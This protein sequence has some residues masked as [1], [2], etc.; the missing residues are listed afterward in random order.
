MATGAYSTL[1]AIPGRKIG[2]VQLV[3]LPEC[4]PPEPLGPPMGVPPQP[5]PAPTKHPVSMIVAHETA[6]STLSVPPSGK[7]IAT[8]S[9]RGT[10]VRVWDTVTGNRLR[11]LRRGSDQAEIYGV[12]F[13]PDEQE[14]CV[15]SDKGTVHVFSL[16]SGSRASYAFCFQP[17]LTSRI[18]VPRRNRHSKLSPLTPFLPQQFKIFGS[19]WSYATYSIPS[20]QSHIAL[21]STSIRSQS[22][23]IAEEDRC[24]VGWIRAAVDE[25]DPA[26]SEY[27]LV[28]LTYTGGWY[29]LKLP[30]DIGSHGSSPDTGSL[31]G[32]P[33]MTAG[34]LPTS[35]PSTRGGIVIKG[36]QPRHRTS[37]VSSMKSDKGKEREKGDG[38]GKP[39]R[40]CTLEEYRKFGRWDGW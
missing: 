27:Q 32:S 18:N 16:V 37:S 34:P 36:N 21:S 9:A 39:S 10:L 22:K 8:T 31:P 3:H 1:L 5:P 25:E 2:H 30:G 26:H 13:R 35:P 11:E 14:L 20:Q 15:W 28:A 24:V 38:D 17:T 23:G 12:A 33:R 6:L 7:L 19:E 40:K 4:I 29:R